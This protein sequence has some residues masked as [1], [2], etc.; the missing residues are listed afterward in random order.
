[1]QIQRLCYHI[2]EDL[3]QISSNEWG[4]DLQ[5][6]VHDNDKTW[7]KH[8]QTITSCNTLFAAVVSTH[9]QHSEDLW[10][11]NQRMLPPPSQY[12]VGSEA[13]GH[14][15][16][17]GV[18]IDQWTWWTWF[19][20][21]DFHF[22]EILSI[23]VYFSYGILIVKLMINTTTIRLVGLFTPIGFHGGKP[24][25]FHSSTRTRRRSK[26]DRSSSGVMEDITGTL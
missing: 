1:M 14:N 26:L 24:T 7:T 16:A 21:W 4:Y 25:N 19:Q 15:L 9:C 2:S 17:W 18:Y 3:E 13:S 20:S 8:W 10:M 12:H 11:E 23:L 22:E 5:L 6:E